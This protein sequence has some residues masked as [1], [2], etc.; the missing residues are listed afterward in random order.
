[1]QDDDSGSKR[2]AGGITLCELVVLA[3]LCA[4]TGDARRLAAAG[5]LR[6]NGIVVA[7]A[8]NGLNAEVRQIRLSAGR[9]RHVRIELVD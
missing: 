5:G 2:Y 1:M 6:L 4:S 8:D 7:H 9:M 3:G